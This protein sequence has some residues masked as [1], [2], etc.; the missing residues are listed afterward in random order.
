MQRL[1]ASIAEKTSTL[2]LLK[3]MGETR[4]EKIEKELEF[5]TMQRDKYKPLLEAEASPPV[6]VD[7]DLI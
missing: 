2:Q 1:E 4:T 3:Q 6:G 7:T 5:E